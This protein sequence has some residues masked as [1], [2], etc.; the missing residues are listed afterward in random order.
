MNLFVL[1]HAVNLM[2]ILMAAMARHR[3][4]NF[5]SEEV[6]LALFTAFA[7]VLTVVALTLVLVDFFFEEFKLPLKNFQILQLTESEY[8]IPDN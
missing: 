6:T 4:F 1:A 2:E 8:S 5:L 3:S 7:A